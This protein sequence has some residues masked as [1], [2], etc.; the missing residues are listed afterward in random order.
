MQVEGLIL[1]WF[2]LIIIIIIQLIYSSQKKQ[3]F[4]NTLKESLV[5]YASAY[6]MTPGGVFSSP[7]LIIHFKP[8]FELE[9]VNISIFSVRHG[10]YS[11]YFSRVVGHSQPGTD[12]YL[13]IKPEGL[14]SWIS[15]KLG[16]LRD[17][18]VGDP[19]IDSRFIIQTNNPSLVKQIFQDV[20]F[21]QYFLAI[22]KLRVFKVIGGQSIKLLAEVDYKT[23]DALNA[24]FAMERLLSIVAPEVKAKPSA[25]TP[26][27]FTQ[28]P[29]LPEERLHLNVPVEKDLLTEAT[30]KRELKVDEKS[31]AQQDIVPSTLKVK[32][33]SQNLKSEFERL[34]AY[35]NKIEYI[36]NDKEFTEVILTPWFGD[37]DQVKYELTKPMRV[38]GVENR[39]VGVEKLITIKINKTRDI[40]KEYPSLSE[41]QEIVSIETNNPSFKES[42]NS[43]YEL[44]RA[45]NK[46]KGLRN[47]EA[48]LKEKTLKIIVDCD[49]KAE[50][51]VPAFSV[52]KEIAWTVKF[53]V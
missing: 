46:L 49:L 11:E 15:K 43:R 26:Y 28:A 40:G 52:I 47:I 8:E 34:R 20:A 50:N 29:P 24:V 39:L 2:L 35:V 14:L 17:I 38:I 41:L 32:S 33:L 13:E 44:L 22:K 31:V 5:Q 18:Q 9:R 1:F 4:F 53:F 6:H 3:T 27:S 16:G 23:S 42:L 7:E 36:P 30:I 10:D 12:F 25:I 19:V 45:V 48:N 51:I 21:R 37:V